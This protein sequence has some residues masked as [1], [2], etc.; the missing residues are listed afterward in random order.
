MPSRTSSRA[1]N[2]VQALVNAFCKTLKIGGA[3]PGR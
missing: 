1:I 3:T 2:T